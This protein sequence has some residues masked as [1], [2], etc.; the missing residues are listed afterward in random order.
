MFAAQPRE[1][2]YVVF[3]MDAPRDITRIEYGGRLYNR[4]PRSRIDFLHSFDGGKN[5][6]QSYSLT[7]TAQPWDVIHYE[8]AESVPAGTRSVLFKYR[9]NSS[10]AGKDV[11]SLYAVRMEAN[12]LPADVTFNPLEVTFRWSERQP[13]YSL[14]ERSHTEV[15][16]NLPHRYTINVGGVDH[17]IVNS[18]QAKTRDATAPPKPGYSDGRDVGGDKFVPRWVTYGRNLARGKPYTV[19]VPSTTQWGA[20]DP[21][22]KKITDGIAGPPYPGGVAPGFAL[23]WNK[24]QNPDITVD[25]GSNERCGAFRIQLGAG[26]PWWDALKGEVK[27]QVELL[28]STD[29]QNFESRG[30]FDFNLRWKDCPANY[31]WPDDETLGAHLFEL[32]LPAPVDARQVRFRLTPARTVTVSEVEVLDFIRFKPF[33]LRLALPDES[34]L[35]R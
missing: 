2:A 4:A 19:S 6:T 20:G 10:G 1:E 25:L 16:T 26:W 17:P 28:T 31:F 30:S 3:R 12:H 35:A 11:C 32:V 8:T 33:D 23:C 21:D 9:L 5:W 14:F 7:N 24:G 18:L 34:V 29:G 15:V 27:D 22:G 13:N